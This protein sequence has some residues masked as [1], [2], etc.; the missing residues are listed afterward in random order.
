MQYYEDFGLNMELYVVMCN[1]DLGLN[2]ELYM[3]ILN[4]S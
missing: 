3:V 4:S 1:E 2:M